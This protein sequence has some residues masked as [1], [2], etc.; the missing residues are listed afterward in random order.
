MSTS[1]PDKYIPPQLQQVFQVIRE[2]MFGERETLM[3][4]ISTISNNNDWYLLSAD[5]PAYIEEQEKVN[6]FDKLRLIQFGKSLMNGPKCQFTMV[7]EQGN[8]AATEQSRSMLIKSGKY[9]HAKLPNRQISVANDWER[10]TALLTLK[11]D[12]EQMESMLICDLPLCL[13]CLV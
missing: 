11:T 4:V 5:F 7:S 10:Q 6:Y 3:K 12:H 2:G 13:N 8:S 1:S 9:L